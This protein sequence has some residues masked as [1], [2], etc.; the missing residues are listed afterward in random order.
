MFRISFKQAISLISTA[1]VGAVLAGCGTG[2]SSKLTD[3]ANL[4]GAD[5]KY[6]GLSGR[7]AI[8]NPPITSSGHGA[9]V[10]GIKGL[11][12]GLSLNDTS[13]NLA[14]TRIAFS[15]S[16]CRRSIPLGAIPDL[17]DPVLMI[18]EIETMSSL[19]A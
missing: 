18:F 8:T 6:G 5:F 16:W 11:I 14:E 13:K 4:N 17:A 7:A 19:S 9:T 15:T 3:S 12:T 2:G 10:T 1:G